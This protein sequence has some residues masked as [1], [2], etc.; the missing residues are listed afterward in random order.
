MRE[1]KRRPHE[2]PQWKKRPAPQSLQSD[3]RTKRRPS[4]S[5]KVGDPELK[6]RQEG[7]VPN[8]LEVEREPPKDKRCQEGRLYP[9]R[10]R[11]ETRRGSS[12]NRPGNRSRPY[13]MRRGKDSTT[14]EFVTEEERLF[15]IEQFERRSSR[16]SAT[17]Q[18]LSGDSM[19]SL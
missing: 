4:R 1:V 2:S 11:A 7:Q 12:D 19:E 10:S 16:T 17:V 3:P 18:V 13:K 6:Y 15:L 9:T 14:T 8:H 5:R